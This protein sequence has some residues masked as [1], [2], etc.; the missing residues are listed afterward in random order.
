MKTPSDPIETIDLGSVSCAKAW[1]EVKNHIKH[2]K[3][4]SFYFYE[5]VYDAF[6]RIDLSIYDWD[7]V[8]F[9]TTD[10][11]NERLKEI[12]KELKNVKIKKG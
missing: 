5:E 6:I 3:D 1:K 10:K 9:L 4:S 7:D 11:C 12:E 2:R 8:E